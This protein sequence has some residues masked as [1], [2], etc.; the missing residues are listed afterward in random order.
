MIILS[1]LLLATERLAPSIVGDAWLLLNRRGAQSQ[2][3]HE[4]SFPMGH[5]RRSSARVE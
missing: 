4:G 3:G 2:T 5:Y 1:K